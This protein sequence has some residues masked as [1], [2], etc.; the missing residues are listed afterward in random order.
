MDLIELIIYILGM[1]ALLGI[2]FWQDQR[3]RTKKMLPPYDENGDLITRD[4]QRF[5]QVGWQVNGGKNDGVLIGRDYA[6]ADVSYIVNHPHGS[7]SPVY[8]EV[9]D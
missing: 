4:G 5:R 8:I 2:W 1:A 3:K 9:G 6:R 7:L